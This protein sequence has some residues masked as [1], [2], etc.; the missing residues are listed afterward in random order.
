[1]PNCVLRAQ[2]NPWCVIWANRIRRE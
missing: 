1:V 2:I